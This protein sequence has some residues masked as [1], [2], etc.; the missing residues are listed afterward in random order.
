MQSRWRK[1]WQKLGDGA[2]EGAFTE[3]TA[4]YAEAHR[5]Y[6]TLQHLAECFA[7]Y[8]SLT[9]VSMNESAVEL[10]I[11]YHDA[12]YDPRATNNEEASATLAK[13]VLT[14]A[15]VPEP[16]VDR[17]S[18]L[19]LSTRHDTSGTS[20]IEEMVL[21]D[22]DLSI[23]GAAPSR[24]FEYESQ[25]RAEYC[26]VPEDQFRAARAGILRRF[27]DRT[28]IYQLPQVRASR[29]ECARRN[30]AAALARLER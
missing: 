26:W 1:T 16:L 10:A 6:H 18:E 12:V 9:T 19:I 24:F 3:L 30:L 17:V 27:L 14:S 2:E 29:E 13:Q 28:S 8:D 15:G 11:W 25:I 21:L 4:R 20:T 5:K 22:V 23:L 7:L